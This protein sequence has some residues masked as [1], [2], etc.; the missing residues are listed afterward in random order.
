[1]YICL[2][3]QPLHENTQ[4]EGEGQRESFKMFAVK[5]GA[6]DAPRAVSVSLTGTA[7]IYHL[8]E[9]FFVSL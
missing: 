9:P 8:Y 5:A 7:N 3:P 1:M 6:R 4:G 2:P